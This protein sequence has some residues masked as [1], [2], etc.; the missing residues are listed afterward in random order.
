MVGPPTMRPNPANRTLF[1]RENCESF[2]FFSIHPNNK[3]RVFDMDNSS[4]SSSSSSQS[5]A[6]QQQH[7]H[8]DRLINANGLYK[9]P[10]RTIC[11]DRFIPCRSSSKFA[12][13]ELSSPPPS[14][15]SSS[16]AYN[17][18]LRTA[19][20][21]P[22]AP[23]TPDK[24]TPNIFRYKTETRHSVHSLSPFDDPMGMVS[25]S[26]ANHAPVVVKPPR[27]V[28]PSPSKVCAF[29]PSPSIC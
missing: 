1:S 8:V 24:R 9:S 22:D 27:K 12:L 15:D 11:S 10:S 29:F 7:D 25:S 20:F 16:A 6:Q 18:L 2:Q 4:S 13:F 3:K 26:E 17:N 23:I 14:S 28:P 19:L 5:Q 21:G